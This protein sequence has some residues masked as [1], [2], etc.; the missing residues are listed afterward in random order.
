MEEEI[1]GPILP[2]LTYSSLDEAIRTVESHPHPLALYFFSEDKKAQKKV[3]DLCHFGGGCI[4][5]TIIHLATSRMGFGGVGASG[6]GSYH[7][8]KSFET[9]SHEKSVVN[10]S[11]WMDLPVR[12][13]PYTKTKD[14]L[15]RKFLK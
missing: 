14:K 8:K 5:D 2:V 6:M 10:K 7:G 13:M 11:T 3:L 15:M 4:N 12:Y 1:F 9:F